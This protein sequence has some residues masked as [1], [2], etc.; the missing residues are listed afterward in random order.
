MRVLWPYG[1]RGFWDQ[2]LLTE[3]FAGRVLPG[4]S[5]EEHLESRPEAPGSQPPLPLDRGAVVV[6]GMPVIQRHSAGHIQSML[7]ALPWA[8]Y[9]H[10]SD[11]ASL[12][13]VDGFR[14]D[15][16]RVWV[17][18]PRPGG[19]Q[20]DRRVLFG[21]QN[22]TRE[23]LRGVDLAPLADRPLRWAYGGQ[24]GSDRRQAAVARLRDRHGGDLLVTDGFAQG[25]PREEHLRVL[26][27]AAIAP[28]PPGPHTPDT[29]RLYEA[30]EAGCLPICDRY[31]R[32]ETDHPD[33]YWRFVLGEEPFPC[34]SSPDE[35]PGLLDTYEADP[36]KL[37][38]DANRA[39]AWWAGYKRNFVVA[40]E[41]D[42]VDLSGEM[43]AR[44][45][46]TVLMPT[47]SIPAHPSTAGVEESIRRVRAY[48]E[49]R[50]AEIILMIDGVHPDHEHRR[51]AYEEYK[52]RL[53]ALCSW[54]PEFAGCVP[55]VFDEW[56]HQANMARRALEMVRTDLVLY[57]E[58]DTFPVG[59]IDWSG[60]FRAFDR[61]D[62]NAIKLSIF[63]RVLEEHRYLMIGD[64]EDVGG[65]PLLRT[66]QWSQRP[67]L[68]RT[69]WYRQVIPELFGRESKA[70]IEDVLWA[71]VYNRL[72]TRTDPFERW[73]LW[74][75]APAGDMTRSATS[76]GRAGERKTP[77][78]IA[79]DGEQPQGAPRPGVMGW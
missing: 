64:V 10:T 68:A 67:H 55:L 77:M 51:A 2:G 56:T 40:L 18:T 9:I 41:D 59:A 19:S 29:F 27:S 38:R 22:D 46:V 71:V 31:A 5:A 11:E 33:G 35:L 60:L 70:F 25:R 47:S 14:N 66:M 21:W 78:V 24:R 16:V 37:Q 58:H 8:I 20:G 69:E 48:P 74:L 53:L 13:P 76:D 4:F 6:C 61:R 54:S 62:V 1:A 50:D 44:H 36:I 12:Y 34:V 23:L 45:R 26:A 32:R 43:M 3:A 73:G 72:S 75:Y 63:D 17:Q 49:L 28:C 42:A 57:V 7:R 30:L 39:G 52:R 65:V 79:Y 15:H